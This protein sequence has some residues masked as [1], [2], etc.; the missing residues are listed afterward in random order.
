M[1]R[2][3]T[4][5]SKKKVIK[6]ESKRKINLQFEKAREFADYVGIKS[7]IFVLRLFRKFGENKVLGI[8]SWLKDAPHEKS[9]EG[10]IIWKLKQ[11]SN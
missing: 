8:K 5:L 1:E 7:P 3:N 4:F 9:L 11:E 10:L 2:I 6:N